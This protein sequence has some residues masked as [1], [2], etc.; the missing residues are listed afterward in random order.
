MARSDL[1]FGNISDCA[2]N[3]WEVDE[4]GMGQTS[5]EVLVSEV[6]DLDYNGGE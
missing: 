4:S 1:S 6:A 3:G 5:A 2:E